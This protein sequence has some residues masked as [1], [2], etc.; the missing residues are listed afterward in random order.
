[1]INTRD[2]L[3]RR[4]LWRPETGWVSLAALAVA[5]VA[6]STATIPTTLEDFFGPGTQPQTIS[7]TVLGSGV[8]MACHYGIDPV[9]EP[10]TPWAASMMGQAARDPIFHA[11]LAIANQDAAFAGDLCLRC[12][13]PRGWLEG[14]S[15]PTNGSGLEP[16]D[17]E[18]VSCHVCHRMVDPIYTP[19]QSPPD[20][21][22][23]LAGL[24]HLPVNPHSGQYIIDPDDRRRGPYNLGAFVLHEWRKSPFHQSSTM[25]ATCH[26]VSNPVYTK[27]PNGTYALNT[28]G[29]PHPT[30]NKY[31]EFPIERT[32]SEWAQSEFAVHPIHMGGRFGGNKP[33]VS[34]CQDCHMPDMT[35]RGSIFSSPRNDLGAHHFNGGNTWVL[36]AVDALYPSAETFLTSDSINDSIARAI[37][38]LQKASD[39]ALSRTGASLRARITNQSG[40]KL[41]TGYPEGRRMWV[42]VRFFDAG[43]TLIAERGH[44]DTTT[45]TLTTGDTVVYEGKLGLSPEVAQ[46]AG[47]PPGESFHFALNNVW[48]KDNRI[49]PRGFTNAGFASVQAAPVDCYY[50]DGQYW[51]D[52]PY[53][54]PAGARR[55]EVRVYYQTTSREYIEF[56]RD[57]NTTN[58][59]GQVAYDQWVLHGKSAPV[60]MDL[61]SIAICRP[62]YNGDGLLNINDF[63][64]FQTGFA[65]SNPGADYS[66]DGVLNVSDYIAF[67]TS[68]ALGCP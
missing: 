1:M 4:G 38:M 5:G 33:E 14:R 35:G 31:D 7:Y 11:C 18:G 6:V 36:R 62:D 25:C 12:H 21:Q 47:L 27:Q 57:E 24:T 67:Q 19:G 51:A 54:I 49:P 20:D 30:H 15:V 10:F 22:K 40:H 39:L 9:T 52:A 53:A 56:L 64:A 65:L 66:G 59:A 34:S 60:E 17:F 45:A 68:F 16:F 2:S 42:N 23:I 13:T 41:P 3:A 43:N 48:I 63:I 29:Q 32:F 55:A 58:N 37:D 28:L 61:G 50:A 26:D 44:Y 46:A 8:C